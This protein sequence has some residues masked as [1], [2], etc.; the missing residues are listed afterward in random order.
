MK[1]V[2]HSLELVQLF[3]C[4]DY[5]QIFSRSFV[6]VGYCQKIKEAPAAGV[7]MVTEFLRT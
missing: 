2:S 7:E 1:V 6:P 5:S 4:L 3:C